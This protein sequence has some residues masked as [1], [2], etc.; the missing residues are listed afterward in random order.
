MKI[1]MKQI[2]QTNVFTLRPSIKDVRSQEEGW[3]VHF[4]N[5]AYKGRGDFFRCGRPHFL[6]QK[7]LD[8]LKFMVCPHGQGRR[9]SIFR[10]FVRMAFGPLQ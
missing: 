5:F 1:K 10:D 8:V 9:G 3:F 6:E 7:T 2:K 4:G